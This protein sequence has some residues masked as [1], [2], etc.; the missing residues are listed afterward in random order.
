VYGYAN[1]ILTLGQEMLDALELSD[2]RVT[3]ILNVRAYS[4]RTLRRGFPKSLDGVP[5]L[6]PTDDTAIRRALDQWL[7]YKACAHSWSQPRCSRSRPRNRD[8]PC[9]FAQSRC[10]F[11]C[12]DRLQ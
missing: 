12:T 1:P 8:E 10:Q 3:P 4:H 2:A 9:G 11:R 5:V 6:L 7:I